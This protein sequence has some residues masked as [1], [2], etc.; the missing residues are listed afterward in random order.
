MSLS[1]V[2]TVEAVC[3]V[4]IDCYSECSAP[5]ISSTCSYDAHHFQKLGFGNTAMEVQPLTDQVISH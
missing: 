4:Q 3:S 1:K 5:L 2:Q